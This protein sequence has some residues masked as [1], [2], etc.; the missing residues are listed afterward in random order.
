MITKSSTLDQSHQAHVK[1]SL[2]WSFIS[3]LQFT[4]TIETVLQVTLTVFSEADFTGPD[5]S[6]INDSSLLS[7]KMNRDI[8]I[9]KLVFIFIVIFF[10]S[11]V[12]T[13]CDKKRLPPNPKL[14]QVCCSSDFDI[15]HQKAVSMIFLLV[16]FISTSF[17][18]TAALLFVYPVLVLSTVAYICT[19]IFCA[20][21]VLALPS[22]FEMMVDKLEKQRNVSEF[23]R[24][25]AYL[26][27]YI[28]YILA[29]I[30]GSLLMLLFLIMISSADN[31]YPTGI[32]QDATSF[33]PSAFLG[34]VGYFAKKKLTAKNKEKRKVTEDELEGVPYRK[35]KCDSMEAVEE[36]RA[37][38]NSSDEFYEDDHEEMESLLPN[39]EETKI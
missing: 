27:D 16:F 7:L 17:V 6:L 28:L 37:R 20:V 8:Q 4:N 19:S 3:V 23:R 11:C 22:S 10:G 35:C 38:V 32:F 21:A 5:S 13:C 31:T 15:A 2:F 26:C 24:N 36:G 18:T 14:K 12:G 33:L 30:A 25:C 29:I 1:I 39:K 34:V 9:A